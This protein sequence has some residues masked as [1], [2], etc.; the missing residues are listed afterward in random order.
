MV[1]KWVKQTEIEIFET[2][3]LESNSTYFNISNR[4]D[5]LEA[6]IQLAI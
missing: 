1:N 4:V 2:F 6:Y 3:N 5:T